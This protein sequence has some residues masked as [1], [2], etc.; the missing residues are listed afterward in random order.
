MSTMNERL[1][2]PQVDND[3]DFRAW[4]RTKGIDSHYM[5]MQPMALKPTQLHATE[6]DPRFFHLVDLKRP[7]IITDDRF[8]LDGHHRV[9]AHLHWKTALVPVLVIDRPFDADLMNE[10]KSYPGVA[11]TGRE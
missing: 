11:F 9:Q 7:V 8:I 2:M 5:R 4:L 1:N 10:V 6:F 3:T